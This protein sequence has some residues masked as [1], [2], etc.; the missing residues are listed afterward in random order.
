[1]INRMETCLRK[2]KIIWQE[3]CFSVYVSTIFWSHAQFRYFISWEFN[4]LKNYISQLQ[5]AS[6]LY[7]PSSFLSLSCC[8]HSFSFNCFSV[9]FSLLPRQVVVAINHGRVEAVG[10]EDRREGRSEYATNSWSPNY[11]LK[12]KFH[13][14]R[15][16]HFPDTAF[17]NKV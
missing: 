6:G 16:R 5:L 17:Y 3:H 10:W 9:D 7:A 1:M 13:Q 4:F 8:F 12:I 15:H 14:L 11:G 2:L